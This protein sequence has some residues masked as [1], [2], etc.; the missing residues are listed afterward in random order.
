MYG[1]VDV[2]LPDSVRRRFD[3]VEEFHQS[4]VNNRRRS[5]NQN[6]SSLTERI[7]IDRSRLKE[8]DSQRSDL[9]RLLAAGGAL[10]TYN[11]L[12]RELGTIPVGWLSLRNAGIPLSDG[13]MPIGICSFDLRSLRCF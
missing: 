12:Q 2:V 5:L 1:Q 7:A 6:K 8:L 9:M 10:E 13:K 4:V 3:E 11:Q